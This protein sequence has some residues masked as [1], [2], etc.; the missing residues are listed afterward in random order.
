MKRLQCF[1]YLSLITLFFCSLN[2]FSK[3]PVAI[4]RIEGQVYDQSRAPVSDVYVELLNEVD[5]LIGRTRT[6]TLGRFSFLGVPAGHFTVKVLPLGKNLLEQSQDIEINNQ[7]SRSD[8]V[9]V[10]FYLK[11]NKRASEVLQETSPEAVFVQDIPKEALRLYK[12]GVGDLEKNQAEGLAK[13]EEAIKIFPDY[14]EALSR[15]G[16]EY[17]ALKNYS[18]AYPYLLKAIDVNP[19]SF[20]SYYSLSYAFYQ[21]GELPA[22]LEAAK[23]CIFINADSLN[24]QLLYGT[25]L[26]ID[27]KYQ[28]SEKA[29]LK[30]KSLAK[31]PNAEI[32]WQL[33][34]LFNK[35]KRNTEAA[36]ELEIYLKIFPDS[37]DKK[38][39]QDLISKLR[40]A[41]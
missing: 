13:I 38:K 9:F 2:V 24:S 27:G 11:S 21:L 36:D 23:A 17:V 32:H 16:K 14:F 40:A 29:L 3:S 8:T 31:K 6:N 30:A 34:L 41:K 37:P 19:R 26:R 12:E 28:D 15:S 22:A 35:L 5:S 39:V 10:D 33:S 20:S 25:I 18:K 4:N 1:F 7:L